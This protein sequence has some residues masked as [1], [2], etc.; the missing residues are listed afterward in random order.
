MGHLFVILQWSQSQGMLMFMI[1][2][3]SQAVLGISIFYKGIKETI[4]DKDFEVFIYLLG[5]LLMVTAVITILPIYY[6]LFYNEKLLIDNGEFL[7]VPLLGVIITIM[8]NTNIWDEFKPDQ[9]K[10]LTYVLLITTI[11]VAGIIFER[12]LK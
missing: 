7:S 9:K 8:F 10:V 5:G 3:A 1:G 6:Q 4:R 2:A 11:P 12:Y